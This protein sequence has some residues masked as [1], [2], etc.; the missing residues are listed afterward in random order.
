MKSLQFIVYFVSIA[1]S[2]LKFIFEHKNDVPTYFELELNKFSS[3]VNIG[4]AFGC[5][6]YQAQTIFERQ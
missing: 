2:L 1:V 3:S 5:Y 4:G 6:L